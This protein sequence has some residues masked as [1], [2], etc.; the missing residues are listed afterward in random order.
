MFASGRVRSRRRPGGLAAQ[1]PRLRAVAARGAGGATAHGEPR[2]SVSLVWDAA[3]LLGRPADSCE[4]AL[5]RRCLLADGT[6]VPRAVAERLLREGTVRDVLA[7]FGMDGSA[8]VIGVSRASR[9]PN[10]RQRR[11]L[12]LQD[13]GCAFPG[14]EAPAH[15][16]DAHHTVA[17]E[18]SRITDL[19]QL[20]LLCRF[21]HHAVHEGG[22]TLTRDRHG[23]TVR[24]PDGTLLPEPAPASSSTSFPTPSSRPPAAH[25]STPR[26]TVRG[27]GGG[28]G[29]D[30]SPSSSIGTIGSRR[31]TEPRPSARWPSCTPSGVR[32][33]S[34]PPPPR[35]PR[36]PGLGGSAVDQ[37]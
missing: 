10:A 23:I 5:E 30:A 4:E 32:R 15:W 11:A 12:D 35:R 18:A 19:D 17:F 36:R 13:Q 28:R 34:R 29:S 24:R 3:D 8:Q 27:T 26:W 7:V 22:F 37:Q 1:R 21:H 6:P 20:A 14:C 16:A 33:R 25:P 9:R 31:G 2:P